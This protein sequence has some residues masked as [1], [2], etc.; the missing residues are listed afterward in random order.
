VVHG[1]FTML[2][3]K[4]GSSSL[5][6]RALDRLQQFIPARSR[7]AIP[8]R[9]RDPCSRF[10][11]TSFAAARRGRRRLTHREEPTMTLATASADVVPRR[12]GDVDSS[13]SRCS[14]R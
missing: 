3:P 2:D 14:S 9:A 1:S 4:V 7:D 10:T 5:Y 6:L 12:R 8:R 13:T 11:S